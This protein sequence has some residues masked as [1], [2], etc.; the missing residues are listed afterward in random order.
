MS[1]AKKQIILYG[2][3][4]KIV[5]NQTTVERDA[6]YRVYI[7][8]DVAQFIRNE[9][10]TKTLKTA[11]SLRVKKYKLDSLTFSDWN[12]G[13]IV[14]DGR[15]YTLVKANIDEFHRARGLAKLNLAEKRALG[16]IK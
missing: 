16:L 1:L 11:R 2:I 4:E 8:K 15:K 12:K 10:N 6:D 9:L 14:L 13:I 5:I 3:I 7:E